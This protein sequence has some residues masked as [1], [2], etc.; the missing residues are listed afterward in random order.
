LLTWKGYPKRCAG[1]APVD[2]GYFS[3]M[4]FY[5]VG[6]DRQAEAYPA[7]LVARREG[8]EEPLEDL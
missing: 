7:R 6:R 5:K 3:L 4:Q 8:L 1:V 2:Q